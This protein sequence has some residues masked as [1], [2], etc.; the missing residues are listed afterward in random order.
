MILSA[1]LG[2]SAV[3]DGPGELVEDEFDPTF[4]FFERETV[5]G[6]AVGFGMELRL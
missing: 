2:V 5:V 3:F 6:P 4:T 1:S